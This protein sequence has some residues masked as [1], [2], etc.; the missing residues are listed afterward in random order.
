MKIFGDMGR[1]F[2]EKVLQPFCEYSNK[3]KPDSHPDNIENS[4]K[5]GDLYNGVGCG[6][7]TLSQPDKWLQGKQ[8]DN[9][10]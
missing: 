10:C 3:P 6:Y 7:N 4:M 1:L 5:K 8:G 2:F 9:S